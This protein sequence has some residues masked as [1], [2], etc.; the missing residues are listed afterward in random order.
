MST[1]SAKLLPSGSERSTL[2]RE[3]VLVA[4][5]AGTGKTAIGRKLAQRFGWVLLD[6]D[7]LTGPF[8]ERL[9]A[10]EC[11]DPW[12]RNSPEYREQVRPLEYETLLRVMWDTLANGLSTVAVAPFVSE[13]T[14]RAWCDQFMSDAK[15]AGVT[16]HWVWVEAYAQTALERLIAR[17]AARDLWKI[18]N[19]FDYWAGIDATARPAVDDALLVHNRQGASLETIVDQIAEFI[20][21]P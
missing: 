4:G 17:D 6:K 3:V 13:V 8:T 14:D 7:I 15:A 5:H 9:C 21:Q 16:V 1:V 10:L 20:R 12:D 2:N 11:G 19:W 18:D